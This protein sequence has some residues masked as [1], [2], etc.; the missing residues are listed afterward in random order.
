MRA[1]GLLS[2]DLATMVSSSFPISD[3]DCLGWIDA[4]FRLTDV[5]FGAT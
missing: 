1:N 5:L 3:I 2:E 4:K